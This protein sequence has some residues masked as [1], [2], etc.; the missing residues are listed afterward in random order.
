MVNKEIS[1][2][3]PSSSRKNRVQTNRRNTSRLIL[4]KQDNT[5]KSDT[6]KQVNEPKTPDERL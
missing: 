1:T 6:N 5:P 3:R 2:M 4:N